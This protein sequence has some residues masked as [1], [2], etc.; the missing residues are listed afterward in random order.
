MTRC[1]PV[2]L[3]RRKQMSERRGLGAGPTQCKDEK[4]LVTNGQKARKS[5]AQGICSLEV[6]CGMG[7]GWGLGSENE[8]LFH[9]QL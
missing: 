3:D 1:V 7:W 6:H 5:L 9:E 8:G 4:E 2:H